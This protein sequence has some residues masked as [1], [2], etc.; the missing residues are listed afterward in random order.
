MYTV[1]T[2]IFIYEVL[3]SDAAH[4]WLLRMTSV[5]V[6]YI[7]KKTFPSLL[8]RYGV[9]NTRL[10][11][12]TGT[13]EPFARFTHSFFALLWLNLLL[14]LLLLLPPHLLRN[15][16]RYDCVTRFCMQ[17]ECL[18]FSLAVLLLLLFTCRFL[19]SS[20]FSTA[21]TPPFCLPSSS[22]M[23]RIHSLTTFSN[24][25]KNIG[26]YGEFNGL[27]VGGG[28]AAAVAVA[29]NPNTPLGKHTHT[30]TQK[31]TI[32]KAKSISKEKRL[33]RTKRIISFQ[34]HS[35]NLISQRCTQFVYIL[36]C[37][38]YCI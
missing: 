8:H 19:S 26:K 11:R 24:N 21:V 34:L 18:F 28:V 17:W 38:M 20:T 30:H 6:F 1:H 29:P 15:I 2:H 22:L 5:N 7:I 27:V 9:G 37:N 10:H 31:T 13:S 16:L 23:P 3:I 12:M 32:S 36:Y 4:L 25:P 35:I 33:C 14:L